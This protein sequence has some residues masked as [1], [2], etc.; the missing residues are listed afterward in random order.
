MRSESYMKTLIG[1]PTV[2]Q[3]R[4]G[5]HGRRKTQWLLF[6]LALI[7]T[8][9]RCGAD[10][11]GTGTAA[12]QNA[13][14]VGADTALRGPV[15]RTWIDRGF[16]S[17]SSGQFD[18]GGSN[19]YVNA[20]GVVELIHRWDVNRDGY[21]DLVLSN[22]HD[23]LERG[24][25]HIFQVNPSQSRGW[26]YE[27]LPNDSGW[28]SLIVD[29]DKDGASDLVIANAW[30]G[31]T[32][33]LSSYVYW[34]GPGGLTGERTELST[35]GAYGL[36]ASDINRDGRPDL[37]FTSA[38]KDPH[39]PAVPMP[40]AVYLQKQR[41]TFEDATSTYGLMGV[42]AMS[43]G[44]DDLNDDGYPDIVVANHRVG[45]SVD[46]NS[47]LYWGTKDGIAASPVELPTHA[48][49]HVV[50]ADLNSD[51]QKDVVFTGGGEARIYWNKNGSFEPLHHLRLTPKGE[52]VQPSQ[53]VVHATV[54]D[55]AGDGIN[56][57]ILATT[58][59]VE[60]RSSSALQ[61]IRSFLP[62]GQTH[63]V[64]A[65]DLNADSKLD[66]IVSRYNDGRRY[67]TESAVFWNVP[68]GFSPEH[69]S[70]LSTGGAMGNTAGD[71]DADGRPEVIFHNT[72]S[73]HVRGVPSYVYFGNKEANYAKMH[74]LELPVDGA[75][76][77]AIADL[78]LDGYPDV[79]FDTTSAGSGPNGGLRIFWGEASG[80][81]LRRFSDL[82]TRNRAV[83]DVRVADFNRDG[84]LDILAVGAINEAKPELL[85]T[86]STVFFGS[87]TGFSESRIQHL[88]NFGFYGAVA[89]VN[90]DGHL[91]ILF[92][93]KRDYVLIYLGSAGGFS[94][95][96]TWKV[97]SPG[98][99]EGASIN[100]ADLNKDGWLDMIVG[101]N[102]A[103]LRRPETLYVF[104]GS[105]QGFSSESQQKL[106]GGYSA[107]YTGVADFN[108]DGHL[109]VAVSAYSSPTT[110][111]LPMQIL[112][113]DGKGVDLQ[114][115]LN[116]PSEG[117]SA[118][119]A[120]DL[121][122]DGWVDAF[123]VNHRNDVGHQVDS[124][125]YWNG[126]DGFR[127]QTPTRLP[128]LG[129]HGSVARDFGNAYTREPREHYISRTFHLG[130][131]I[132]RRVLWEAVV[133]SS[134]K[135]Q[136]QLRWAATRE[137]L[138]Q[139]PWTGARGENTYFERSGDLVPRP[140]RSIRWVQYRAAFVSPYGCASPQLQEVRVELTKD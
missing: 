113:G 52:R 21:V 15:V 116:L 72:M 36:A 112:W 89:D 106:V 90:R 63:W 132:P 29:L 33:E 47:F 61:E 129:P 135:L 17:F 92:D 114:H 115:P 131:L 62:L 50:L 16:A 23:H 98:M 31:V 107:G 77:C 101:V 46:T 41:R 14:R 49:S 88:S 84:Y 125:I 133:P 81:Q 102:A 27:S 64:T 124:V 120:M 67:D 55:L 5:S 3:Q 60:I 139:A 71:L 39:N 138:E 66:L 117:S 78:N 126:P 111:I 122:R 137:E 24:P 65:S 86:A 76:V 45:H 109:D 97:P 73:G 94:A 26:K 128:G 108:N 95:E 75:N 25:T 56:D 43:L 96:R 40:L 20:R 91:D 123:V 110:R 100:V 37:I 28:M 18:D 11:G 32:A 80:N 130:E 8:M 136:L 22:T 38:W 79:V 82:A 140:A 119:M 121:N 70:W 69:T 105:P 103:R 34:G 68:Q 93:D 118:V 44:V 2:I 57:L 1:N 58:S 30:N 83:M 104:F 127:A 53:G 74:R 7:A 48:A 12:V 59:G 85:A 51:G 134:T 54:A 6:A 35:V 13:N 10:S 42:G 19:L 9:V 99:G 87:K 4:I